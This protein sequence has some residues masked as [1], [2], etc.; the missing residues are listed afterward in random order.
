MRPS[1]T[2]A[3]VVF[4]T[5]VVVTVLPA[6]PVRFVSD[7]LLRDFRIA[8]RFGSG[9]VLIVGGEIQGPYDTN[10]ILDTGAVEKLPRSTRYARLQPGEEIYLVQPHDLTHFEF[11]PATNWHRG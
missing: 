7:P 10:G 9:Q 3:A 8:L 4:A 6:Q 5:T 11:Q 1:R 2:M